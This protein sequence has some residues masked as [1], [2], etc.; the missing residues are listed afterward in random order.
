MNVK[1]YNVEN[2]QFAQVYI[3]YAEYNNSENMAKINQIKQQY[4]NVTIFVSGENDTVKTIKEMLNYEKSG[5]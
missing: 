4:T 3:N 1:T 2:K 5:K